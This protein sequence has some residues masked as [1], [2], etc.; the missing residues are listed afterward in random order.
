MRRGLYRV[1][2]VGGRPDDVRVED[3]GIELPLEESLYRTRGYQP[4]VDDLPWQEEYVTGKAA[5]P[6]DKSAAER[7]R[8]EARREFRARYH[9]G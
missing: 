6:S 2:G 8:E 5:A 1:H 4:E 9:K 7:A 3:D